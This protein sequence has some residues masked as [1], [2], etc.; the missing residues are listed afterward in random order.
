MEQNSVFC[1]DQKLDNITWP[2]GI[3][4]NHVRVAADEE[5]VH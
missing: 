5:K 4:I 3:W 2:G 1:V